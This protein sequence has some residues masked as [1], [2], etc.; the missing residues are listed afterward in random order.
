[1][2][3]SGQLVFVAKKV[4]PIHFLLNVRM[5]CARDVCSL[6]IQWIR[7][8]TV[9][10]VGHERQGMFIKTILGSNLVRFDGTRLELKVSFVVCGEY[11]LNFD[12]RTVLV[13]IFGK[14]REYSISNGV[15]WIIVV[16]ITYFTTTSFSTSNVEAVRAILRSWIL[17]RASKP[18]WINTGIIV[19]GTWCFEVPMG[20]NLKIGKGG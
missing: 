20:L 10:I 15:W 12:N 17:S 16:M 3:T 8:R 1:M 6:G 11:A 9:Q 14:R 4:I 19:P 2:K 7:R 18:N 5:V 13:A